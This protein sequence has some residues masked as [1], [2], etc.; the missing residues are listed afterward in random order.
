MTDVVAE[1][2]LALLAAGFVAASMVD[3]ERN[4]AGLTTTFVYD[5]RK[6]KPVAVTAADYV[7]KEFLPYAV[8]GHYPGPRQV[9]TNHREAWQ[10]NRSNSFEI[11]AA[12]GLAPMTPALRVRAQ[13]RNSAERDYGCG[14]TTAANVYRVLAARTLPFAEPNARRAFAP[15]AGAAAS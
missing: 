1:T 4:D 13:Q 9:T 2:V 14:N 10:D 7:Q 8:A 3:R 15:G 11:L 6:F 12:R 5:E